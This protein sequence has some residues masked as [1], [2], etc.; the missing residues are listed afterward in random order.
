MTG[1][2]WAWIIG[3]GFWGLLVVALCV[4]LFNVFRLLSELVTLIEGITNETVPLIGQV[5][6]TVSGVNV[7]LAR[8]DSIVAGV[9]H[10]TVTADSL[11]GLVHATLSNPL[12]K[13]AAYAAGARRGLKKLKE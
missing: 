13:A 12:V 11:V 6:E 9:Q 1:S 4:V 10:I 2:D 7:E 3:A 8:V 5:R